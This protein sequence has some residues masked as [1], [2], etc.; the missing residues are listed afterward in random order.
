MV[1]IAARV[2]ALVALVAVAA[3]IYLI[4][5]SSLAKHHA[6]TT[7]SATT[8]Q[9]QTGHRGGH[10]RARPTFYTVKSGDTLSSIAQKTGVS[11]SQ[12]ATLNPSVATPPYSLQTGQRL[13]LRPRR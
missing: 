7:R 1:R 3:T 9:Q 13:R 8:L 10:R 11:L 2:V 5:H 6:T 12:L 4:V